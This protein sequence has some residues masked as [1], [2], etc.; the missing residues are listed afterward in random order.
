VLDELRG[1]IQ[2]KKLGW[3]NH[4]AFILHE[5]MTTQYTP[6]DQAVSG[7]VW[8]GS[9]ATFATQSGPDLF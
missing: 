1:A 3:L 7:P 4:G 2:R 5:N 6:D 9:V 8:A